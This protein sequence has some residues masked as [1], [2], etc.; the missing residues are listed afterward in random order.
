MG[1]SLGQ[2]LCPKT[3]FNVPVLPVHELRVMTYCSVNYVVSDNS[4]FSSEFINKII[5]ICEIFV[6]FPAST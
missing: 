3:L 2:A 1:I 4:G 6:G 5:I